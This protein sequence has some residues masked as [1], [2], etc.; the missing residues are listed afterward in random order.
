M[1]YTIPFHSPAFHS[2]DDV[3]LEEN[4]DK[5]PSFAELEMSLTSILEP[6]ADYKHGLQYIVLQQKGHG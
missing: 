4:A 3:L 2:P 5:R 6:L 1:H